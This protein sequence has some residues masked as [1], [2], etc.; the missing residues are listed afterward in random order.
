MAYI[1][2]LMSILLNN[3]ILDQPKLKVFTDD[4]LKSCYNKLASLKK[5]PGEVS[6]TNFK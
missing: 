4:N 6:I 1:V 5:K 3:K 2:I